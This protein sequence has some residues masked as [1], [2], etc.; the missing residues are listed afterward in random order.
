MRNLWTVKGVIYSEQQCEYK[1]YCA[2]FANEVIEQ[3]KTFIGF[4]DQNEIYTNQNAICINQNE[5]LFIELD[6]GK[7][8][9][10]MIYK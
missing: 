4:S 5:I 6:N 3:N 9:L 1:K 8:K 2:S 10:K 7:K